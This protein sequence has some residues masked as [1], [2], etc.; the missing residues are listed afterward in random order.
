M[1]ERVLREADP[2]AL[3]FGDRL[4]IYY[5]PVAVRAMA[6]NVDAIAVNYNIASPDGWVAPY[7]FDGLRRLSGGKPVLIS[8]WFFAAR[9]NRTGNRNNGHPMAGGT[10]DE[11]AAG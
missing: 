1:V 9:E 2:D 6:R 10:Q 4:P 8:E 11:R 7:F 5:D 3:I